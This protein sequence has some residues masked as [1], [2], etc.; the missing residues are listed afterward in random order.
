M[1]AR[2][3]FVLYEGGR[4][5]F[6]ESVLVYLAGPKSVW[7]DATITDHVGRMLGA[8]RMQVRRSF[9]APGPTGI[10]DTGGARVL[11]ISRRTSF[12]SYSFDVSGVAHASYSGATIGGRELVMEANNERFGSV[13]GPSYRGLAGTHLEILDQDRNQVGAIR[14]FTTSTSIFR[15][16]DDYVMSIDPSVHGEFRR[17]LVAAPVIAAFM[18]RI[19]QNQT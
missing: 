15:S 16:T 13:R 12:F 2:S 8:V 9:Q 17:L 14:S 7:P 11:H 1:V 19:Q 4:S 18:K 5:V 6:D 3:G 10:F